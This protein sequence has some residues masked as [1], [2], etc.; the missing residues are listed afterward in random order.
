MAVGKLMIT[1]YF[2][3]EDDLSDPSKGIYYVREGNYPFAFFLSGTTIEPF[4]KTILVRDNEKKP[5]NELYPGFIEWSTSG[6]KNNK[7]W[8]K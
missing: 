3:T 1:S 5:I 8:Y 4:K 2:G 6:G 7:D